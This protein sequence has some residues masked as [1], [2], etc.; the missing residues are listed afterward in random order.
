VRQGDLFAPVAT[1]AP[2]DAVVSNPP[3]VRTG[4]LPGLQAEVRREPRLALDGGPEGL[5]VLSQVVEAAFLHLVPGGLLALEIGEEQG[6][7]VR[8][9]LTR[10]G[11]EAVHIEPDLEGRDRMAFGTRPRG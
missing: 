6:E 5:T 7:A 10:R 11:Y 2:F 3:Y 8:N 1:E 9:L 4:D